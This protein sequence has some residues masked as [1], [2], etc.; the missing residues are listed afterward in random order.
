MD[1][2]TYNVVVDE[3]AKY[4]D[5]LLDSSRRNKFLNFTPSKYKSKDCWR[6]YSQYL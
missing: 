3:I 4:R 5:N 2:K 1:S 6:E